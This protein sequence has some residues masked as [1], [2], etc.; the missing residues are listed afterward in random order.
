MNPN[1][2]VCNIPLVVNVDAEADEGAMRYS[3]DVKGGEL[4]DVHDHGYDPRVLCDGC[5]AKM[6]AVA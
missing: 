6:V 3:V 1:C 2:C 4:C 5:F